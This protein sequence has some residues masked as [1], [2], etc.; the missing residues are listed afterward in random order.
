MLG[1]GARCKPRNSEILLKLR[2]LMIMIIITTQSRPIP[3]SRRRA[4]PNR[5]GQPSPQE[6]EGPTANTREGRA[7]QQEGPTQNRKGRANSHCEKRQLQTRKGRATPHT[8]EGT[9]KK[10]GPT[11]TP[12]RKDQP[13]PREGPTPTQGPE[14]PTAIFL[15]STSIH[16]YSLILFLII[17]ISTERWPTP[18]PRQK[19]QPRLEGPTLKGQSSSQERERP[20][21]SQ[22]RE[23]QY[24]III[25]IIIMNIIFTFSNFKFKKQKFWNPL[26]PQTLILKHDNNKNCKPSHPPLWSRVP[27]YPSFSLGSGLALPF[28]FGPDLACSSSLRLG[29]AFPFSPSWLGLAKLDPEN[30]FYIF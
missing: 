3:T 10:E 29:L 8:R 13:P 2:N 27:P 20:T 21:Q 24:I 5:K 15:S 1:K 18:S 28:P 22:E 25:K 11:P 26:A 12:R 7:N 30:I 17:T 16:T 6:K 4:N 23:R 9:A 14:G 19:G